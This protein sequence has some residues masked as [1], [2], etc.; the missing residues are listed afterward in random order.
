MLCDLAGLGGP[1]GPTIDLH[2]VQ[3]PELGG[4]GPL[5]CGSH[6]FRH[7]LI[8]LRILGRV[9]GLPFERY[10]RSRELLAA[11]PKGF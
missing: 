5:F 4:L 1:T 6:G 2:G 11:R 3:D 9:R 8:R 7:V 10:H